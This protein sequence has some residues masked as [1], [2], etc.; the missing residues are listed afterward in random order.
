M[1]SNLHPS[2]KSRDPLI[3]M[4]IEKTLK[5]ITYY[6]QH[7]TIIEKW[8]CFTNYLFVSPTGS[9]KT[10]IALRLIHQY[11]SRNNN[12]RALVLCPTNLLVDQVYESFKAFSTYDITRVGPTTLVEQLGDIVIATGHR[13]NIDYKSGKW[14]PDLFSVVIFDEVHKMYPESSPYAQI[15]NTIKDHAGPLI[16]CS[17]TLPSKI[18][19]KVLAI[20]D[21]DT[22]ETGASPVNWT[23]NI[24]FERVDYDARTRFLYQKS[25]YN[26]MN[27][28]EKI[29]KNRYNKNLAHY[30]DEPRKLF[31]LIR[32]GVH[33]FTLQKLV[34]IL[35]LRHFYFHECY[36]TY[37]KYLNEKVKDPK[38]F[39]S[40]LTLFLSYESPKFKKIEGI[41]NTQNASVIIFMDN[42][43][44]LLA[45]KRHLESKAYSN[46]VVLGGKSKIS[47][48]ERRRCLEQIKTTTNNII[49]TTSVA[50]EGLDIG[51][52]DTVI[53]YH[54]VVNEIK[55]VQRKGRTGRKRMGNVH[56]LYY[57]K[58]FESLRVACVNPRYKY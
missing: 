10:V 29:F 44:T 34:R 36:Q 43:S 19:K 17:A 18:A 53:C 39:W 4:A 38:T 24:Y 8:D 35:Y 12:A 23:K 5:G 50:E 16:G 41:L 31:S 13:A 42:Y 21:I 37:E 52:A 54:P 25:K 3:A 7:T 14:A 56:I 57:D 32:K 1:V 6:E 15:V 28:Y 22:Y 2:K 9:G 26:I 58:T 27:H 45:L 20:L 51:S 33:D 11:L 55:Y 30:I 46:I 47:E 48:K 49:L 40:Y